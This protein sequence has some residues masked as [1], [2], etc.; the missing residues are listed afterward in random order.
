ML[1]EALATQHY[2]VD[3]ATDGQSG[4]ELAEAFEYDLILLD[5]MLPKLD[6]LSFC[7]QLRKE[8]DRTPILLLTAQ[9][10]S[11]NKVKGLDAGAD[12]YVVKP[13]D[14]HEL[15]ARIRALLRRDSATATPI[16]EWGNLSLD[17]VK[18]EVTYQGKPLRLTAKEY[19]L[20]ELF[21]R[22]PQRIF[23]QSALLDHL[24]SFDE[25]PTEN[26]VRAHI[27]S[28]RQKLKK[29]GAAA[30]V[31]ETVYGLGYRL[32]S[33]EELVATNGAASENGGNGIRPEGDSPAS[34]SPC[35]LL[36]TPHL[37]TVAEQTQPAIPVELIGVWQKFKDKYSDRVTVLDQAV[38]ALSNGTLSEKL[39]QQA[40][41]EAH[42]L[43]GSLGSFGLLE[44]SG[45]S[46]EIEQTFQTPERLSQVQQ[47]HLSQKVVVLQQ[48]LS[49]PLAPLE[50]VNR[51]PVESL[52]QPITLNQNPQLL[53]VDDDEALGMA[54]ISEATARGIQAKVVTNL[55]QARAAIAQV[56]PDAV[57]LD[58]GFPD[59]QDN[60]FGLLAELT[61]YQPPVPV[62]V[63]TGQENFADRVKV[64]RLGGRGFLHKPVSPSE[65]I[66]A[67]AQLLQQSNRHEAKLLIV[68]DDPQ[69][70]DFLRTLLEP[71]AFQL[72]LL[73]D[74]KQF[75]T[76]LEQS[77]PDLLILDIEMP[78]LSGIDLCQVVRNDPHWSEL[79]VL[80]LSAYIDAD[81]VHRVFTIG[82]DDYV[83]KPIIGPELVARVLNRL[84]RTK[85][86]QKL[87]QLSS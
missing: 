26:A 73:D 34:H 32:K 44:A 36:P 1:Q 75:W 18:C 50:P 63:F 81:T 5:W 48:L 71:W 7:K 59:S 15:F 9:N 70:L 21:L 56:R 24:W 22:N 77:A 29:A 55:S 78:E 39:R 58:L 86:R 82:A 16:I 10:S 62:V 23:S 83:S 12:D 31:I 37:P 85:I 38:K 17:P 66:N 8:G 14:L 52:P 74:P 30:D 11:A 19:S 6:G 41:R 64:A 54:L 49:T 27:K 43:A 57:L 72:T 4:W 67:I 20:L 79:P 40:L 47:E 2:L 51:L 28:L 42:T 60:G 68:D 80:F 33:K 13:F 3:L 53:I 65:V 69:L 46:R 84:E 87:W 45:L 35:P 61:A 25:P 76:I